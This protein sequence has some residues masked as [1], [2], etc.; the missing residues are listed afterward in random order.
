MSRQRHFLLI[1]MP[2]IAYCCT[3]LA[4][5]GQLVAIPEDIAT[6]I[7]GG[8][9][10]YE[11]R[12]GVNRVIVRT[13]GFEHI[14]SQAQVDWIADTTPNTGEAPQVVESKLV[15]TGS[16]RLDNPRIVKS[17]NGWLLYLD[18]LETHFVPAIRGQWVVRL[19]EPG[20]LSAKQTKR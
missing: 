14:V 11:S 10:S 9:W 15:P 12:A 8:R 19:G 3:A 5:D 7:S 13:G 20:K 18:G 17:G 6:V 16:W 2:M 4:Q 1:L